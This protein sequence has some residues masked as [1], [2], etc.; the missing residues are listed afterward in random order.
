MII[1][2]LV[3][4][5]LLIGAP[6]DA[7][8]DAN[9][10]WRVL[11]AQHVPPIEPAESPDRLYTWEKDLRWFAFGLLKEIRRFWIRFTRLLRRS[12]DFWAS[13]IASAAAL[14]L[15]AGVVSAIDRR[16]LVLAWRR[17]A[18]VALAYALVG[19]AVFLRL[20]RD[21]RVRRRVRWIIPL[22][23]VYGVASSYWVDLRPAVPNYID[24]VVVMAIASR[25]FVRRCPDAIVEQHAA[26]VREH[27]LKR[28]L[29]SSPEKGS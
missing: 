17:G 3:A 13:W 15:F 9:A 2:G 14:L 27:G 5:L 6:A 21:R 29:V 24:E 1:G 23:I 20:L 28:L 16:L 12:V 8:T 25:W 18:R 7:G 22:A 26:H 19:V 4:V 11:R 10:P